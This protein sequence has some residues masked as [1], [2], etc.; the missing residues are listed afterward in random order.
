MALLLGTQIYG[1]QRKK[2]NRYAELEE[3]DEEE[4]QAVK[5]EEDG[6]VTVTVDSGASKSV[7]PR[8]KKGVLRRE[9]KNKP[10]LAAAN[11]TNMHFL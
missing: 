11:G 4:V 8:K 5:Q 3:S 10:K 1:P 6:M 2:N 7:W 9:M